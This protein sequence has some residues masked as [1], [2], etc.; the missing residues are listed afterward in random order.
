MDQKLHN[1]CTEGNNDDGDIVNATFKLTNTKLY[2]P[3]VT[4]STKDNVKLTKQLNEGFKRSV[5]WNQYKIKICPKYLDNNNPIRLPLDAFFKGLKDCLFLLLI[6]L[7]MIMK[8][9]KETAI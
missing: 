8:K 1:V 9:L 2:V 7:I 5:Y 3:I 4:L 6:I